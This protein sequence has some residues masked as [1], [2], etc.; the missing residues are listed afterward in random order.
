MAPPFFCRGTVVISLELPYLYEW[1]GPR[2][3]E[4]VMAIMGRRGHLSR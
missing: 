2:N 4:G 3:E 1:D